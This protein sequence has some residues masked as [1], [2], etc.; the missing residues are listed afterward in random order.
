MSNLYAFIKKYGDTL[1]YGKT[2]CNPLVMESSTKPRSFADLVN[3]DKPVFIDF[4]A[5]WCGPCRMMP[6]ILAELKHK[7]GDKPL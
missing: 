3:G 6:P 1:R 2:N 5:A 7:T 4:T